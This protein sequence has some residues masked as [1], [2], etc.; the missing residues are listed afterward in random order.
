MCVVR[1]PRIT[2]RHQ[3]METKR[4]SPLRRGLRRVEMG[5]QNALELVRFGRFAPREGAP[6]EVVYANPIYRLRRYPMP[7]GAKPKSEAPLPPRAAAHGDAGGLRHRA[8]HQ[9]R[10]RAPRARRRRLSSSTS[11]RPSTKRAAWSARSTT[12]SAR[13][14]TRSRASRELT[15]QRRAP[16]RLLAGRHVRLSG[17]RVSA[18][19]RRSR[20]SSRSAARSTSTGTCP[21]CARG[22]MAQLV[23]AASRWSSARCKRIEGLPGVL[24]ST[25]FKLALV[26]QGGAAAASTSS[27]SSTIA[28]RS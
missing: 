1:R 10:R 22:A 8:R 5:A 17:G 20:R 28:R 25:G 3:S 2:Y 11:A 21:A 27:G 7:A 26:P 19:R 12:T 15:G 4:K 23:R 14:P 6:F 24:T 9:R 13:S 18:R 16:R